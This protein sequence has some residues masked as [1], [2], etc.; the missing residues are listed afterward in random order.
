[1][2][3]KQFLSSLIPLTSLQGIPDLISEFEEMAPKFM[4]PEALQP[5]DTIGITCTGGPVNLDE[6]LPSIRQLESWGFKVRLGRNPGKKYLNFGGTDQERQEEL[7]Q[8]LDDEDIRAILFARG[9]YGTVRIIDNLDFRRFLKRPQWLVGFSDLTYL[10]SLVLSKRVACL[11][12]KMCSSFPAV[13]EDATEEQKFS[14]LSIKNALTGVKSDYVSGPHPSNIAGEASGTL[15]GGNLR[16]LESLS[17]TATTLQT[18]GCILFLED[19]M[20]YLYSI[21]RMFWNLRRSG[22]LQKLKGLIIGGFRTKA[23]DPGEEF[24]MTLEQIILEKVKDFGYPVCFGFPVG[25]QPANMALKCG[26]SHRLVV[27]SKG[28]YLTEQ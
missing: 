10:H 17:G 8:M 9:G 25:H 22:K 2:K 3:R 20:E 11:H 4:I 24:G 6:I 26:V 21:D 27:N 13:W 7:Q 1:M 19:T 23:D 15:L 18:D 12:S 5:G 14:I 28:A 16:I